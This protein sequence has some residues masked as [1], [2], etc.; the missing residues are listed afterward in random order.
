MFTV[1]IRRLSICI[2]LRKFNFLLPGNLKL[3]VF[4]QLIFKNV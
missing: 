4:E 3:L 2:N 1:Q